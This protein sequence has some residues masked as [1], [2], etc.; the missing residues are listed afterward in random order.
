MQKSVFLFW[1]FFLIYQNGGDSPHSKMQIIMSIVIVL[2]LKL[3]KMTR[4]K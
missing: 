4:R 3:I 1:L 2:N